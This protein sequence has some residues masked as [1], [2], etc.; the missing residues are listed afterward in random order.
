MPEDSGSEWTV[1]DDELTRL[2]ELFCQFEGAS[3]PRALK[4]REAEAEFNSL[5]DSLYRT[6]VSPHFRSLTFHQF[7]RFV[8]NQCRVRLAKT[9]PPFPCV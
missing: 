4:C 8:R 2:A 7:R 9:L 5:L 6:K 1:S 3:D